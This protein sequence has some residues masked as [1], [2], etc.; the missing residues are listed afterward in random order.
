MQTC[1]IF[2]TMGGRRK[3]RIVDHT[4]RSY[5]LCTLLTIRGEPLSEVGISG[6]RSK[7]AR[8]AVQTPQT[9]QTNESSL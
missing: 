8:A 2:Q 5:K 3:P 7:K 1:Q 4:L 9:L 6:T